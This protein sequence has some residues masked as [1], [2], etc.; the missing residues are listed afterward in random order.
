[1]TEKTELETAYVGLKDV[2]KSQ[3]QFVKDMNSLEKRPDYDHLRQLCYHHMKQR[4]VLQ[5]ETIAL[6][7]GFFR[8]S[9][10]QDVASD[11]LD[12][13]FE[14][15]EEGHYSKFGDDGASFALSGLPNTMRI[16]WNKVRTALLKASLDGEEKEDPA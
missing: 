4:S 16:H 5:R 11:L 12:L 8:E 6:V 2:R 7:K 15:I 13:I 10:D 3:E 14:K 9:L 1:M